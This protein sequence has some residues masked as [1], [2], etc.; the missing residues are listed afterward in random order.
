[1]THNQIVKRFRLFRYLATRRWNRR[2]QD[3]L[4]AIED[5]VNGEW[6][7]FYNN[8][9]TYTPYLPIG[10]VVEVAGRTVVGTRLLPLP[11]LNRIQRFGLSLYDKKRAPASQQGALGHGP[12]AE[13]KD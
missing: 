8:R 10:T 9:W 4:N 3:T 2:G 6:D 12:V 7:A 11:R 1:V 5:I 13:S